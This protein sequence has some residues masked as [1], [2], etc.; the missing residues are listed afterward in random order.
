MSSFLD[1][2]KAKA[3]EARVLA[4]QKAQD[5]AAK[6]REYASE[7]KEQIATGID[8]VE[9]AVDKRTKGRYSDKITKAG[10]KADAVLDKVAG[11]GDPAATGEAP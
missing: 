6:S 9:Q 8:K 10:D 3:E 2:A 5:L 4:A 7:H 11:P 1:K